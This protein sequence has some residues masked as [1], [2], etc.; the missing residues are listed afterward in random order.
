MKRQGGSAASWIAMSLLG[1]ALLSGA[2][3]LA[4]ADPALEAQG[5]CAVVTPGEARSL[6]DALYQQGAYQ[7]AGEC[8][9]IAGDSDRA[10]VAFTRALRPAS[11][12]T[13]R[14]ASD[15]AEQAKALVQR[16]KQALH[17]QQ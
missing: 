9:Q 16:Y 3:S 8:Y 11:A 2:S 15:Q 6:A 4:L 10:N 14:R 12:V 5:Q 17:L 13:A 1:L 7:R